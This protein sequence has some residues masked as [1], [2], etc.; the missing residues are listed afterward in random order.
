MTSAAHL[1]MRAL[2]D[3]CLGLYWYGFT[4]HFVR[5]YFDI[6]FCLH[7]LY[8]DFAISDL[9]LACCWHELN[10]DCLESKVGFHQ[11]MGIQFR[12]ATLPCKFCS[13][14]IGIYQKL[15]VFDCNMSPIESWYDMLFI[16]DNIF[17]SSNF[18]NSV[19]LKKLPG[20]IDI[21][22]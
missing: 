2:D 16:D 9:Y 14:L 12:I 13:V 5:K 10:L 17:K 19:I 18:Q 15:Y 4:D 1:Q 3:G 7:V 8:L 20:N 22:I 6:G 21:I 11:S